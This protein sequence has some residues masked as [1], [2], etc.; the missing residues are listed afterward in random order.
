MALNLGEIF[1]QL[2]T[3]T[4]Q[5]R[6]A[7]K[8]VNKFNNTVKQS[9]R[10]VRQFE[11]N[12]KSS[13]TSISSSIKLLVAS[14]TGIFAA[15]QI[16][17][18]A[19][20]YTNLSNK[21]R[22]VT[23]SER[24]A[25]SVKEQLFDISNRTR[26]SLVAVTT[27][28]SRLSLGAD[29]LRYSQ[30]QLLRVVETLNKQVLIGG[31][32]LQEASQGLVQFAQGI[33]SG[34]L[35]GDE[36]RSVMENLLGVQRGLIK[37]FKNL[38]RAGVIDFEVTKKNIRDLAS[39][40]V[41]SSDLLIKALL[42]VA[43]ETDAAF[44]TLDSTI[45][46]GFQKLANE[47][48]K[49]VGD[50]DDTIKLSEN[51]IKIINLLAKNLSSIVG[52]LGQAAVAYGILKAATLA[53]AFATETATVGTLGLGGSIVR[54][55]I[56]ARLLAASFLLIRR[57]IPF[58]AVFLAIESAVAIYNRTQR[59]TL[60]LTQKLAVVTK[61]YEQ[62]VLGIT[63]AEEKRTAAIKKQSQELELN[64]RQKEINRLNDE[65]NALY[66][67]FSGGAGTFL[68]IDI[69]T[70]PAQETFRGEDQ[71]IKDE[72]DT[73]IKQLEIA[74][75]QFQI[76]REQLK[77]E[78][79]EPESFIAGI[80]G[81]ADNDPNL[82]T[83]LDINKDYA[84]LLYELNEESAKAQ[85]DLL[86]NI[87]SAETD[88][89]KDEYDRRRVDAEEWLAE[90]NELLI[91]SEMANTETAKRV[92]AVHQQ[93]LDDIL[94]D[95]IAHYEELERERLASATDW[96]SGYERAVERIR[97]ETQDFASQSERLAITFADGFAD[98]FARI[99]ETG[100]LSFASLARSII[101]ELIRIQAKAVALNLL[102]LFNPS[103]FS[104][105]AAGIQSQT[106]FTGGVSGVLSGA[107]FAGFKASGGSVYRD[108]AYIVGE[109][110]AEVF[111]PNQSGNIIANNQLSSMNMQ[112][113]VPNINMN[114]N[115]DAS[116]SE[117][118]DT[119]IQE[120]ADITF[121]RVMNEVIDRA[122]GGGIE[123]VAFGVR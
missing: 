92:R 8:E 84:D 22:L 78:I 83:F 62:V 117:A 19:D 105:S 77:T 66:N 57:V 73:R 120:A 11:R 67:R 29:D 6:Q 33:A 87:K 58:T 5:I 45:A 55:S 102:S 47:A 37:G 7:N 123:S 70:R 32:N 99:A 49:F 76:A 34:R 39:S 108:K 36:L 104:S 15:I 44:S 43:D 10:D 35:Q 72:I 122:Q 110:G 50:L 30:S 26:Q 41:L 111:V 82:Q 54:T 68:E 48:L 69:L 65:I 18:Y 85:A 109:R 16:K 112:K 116:G 51:V 61:E 97:D 24:E 13:F 60:S 64:T 23:G 52:N 96:V 56:A 42:S 107:E 4:K 101:A 20:Q 25:I 46:Q 100:K 80:T 38:Q 79:P 118:V 114:V 31:N 93:M 106:G 94:A 12:T 53:Y 21:I 9:G 81:F 2:G 40:G 95:E 59:E 28:Y 90:Q 91:Q 27:L 71:K 98:S 119:R 88:L 103:G 17:N 63:D 74:G 3:D 115:I 121:R 86:Q 89:I 113:Q 75:K 1:F 14:F